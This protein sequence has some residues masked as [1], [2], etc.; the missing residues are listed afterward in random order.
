MTAPQDS[1]ELLESLGRHF[2]AGCAYLT[3]S[4]LADHQTTGS[5]PECRARANAACS[6][7][8]LLFA[9]PGSGG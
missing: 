9:V 7:G 4:Q 1:A 3:G 6:P 2:L 8:L 5:C